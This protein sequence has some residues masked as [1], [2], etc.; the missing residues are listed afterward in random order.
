MP[1]DPQAARNWDRADHAYKHYRRFIVAKLDPY[2]L[3][4]ADL[5]FVKNFKGGMAQ[6][7]EPVA[8]FDAKLR[9]YE[10]ALRACA[11]DPGFALTFSMMQDSEYCRVQKVIVAFAAKPEEPASHIAGFG[12]SFASALLHFY[13]PRIVPIL[14]K[15]ALNG[16]NVQGLRVDG[17]RIVTNLLPLYPALIDAFRKRLIQDHQLTLRDIDRE[18]FIEKL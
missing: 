10:N 4:F 14:D 1:I 18:W 6:I 15:R 11:A 3:D 12:S 16:S 9:L 8:N 5:A 17:G 7:A 13:F 2:A